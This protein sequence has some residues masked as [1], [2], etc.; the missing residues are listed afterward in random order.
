MARRRPS[1][2]SAWLVAGRQALVALQLPPPSGLVQVPDIEFPLTVPLTLTA[3]GPA[4][5]AGPAAVGMQVSPFRFWALCYGAVLAWQGLLLRM[6]RKS[7]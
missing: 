5:T 7:L 4:L 1:R 6:W 3:A 2:R